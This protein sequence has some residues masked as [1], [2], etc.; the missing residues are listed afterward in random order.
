MEFFR[1]KLGRNV[2]SIVII[3]RIRK[4]LATN[5]HFYVNLKNLKLRGVHLLISISYKGLILFITRIFN[6]IYLELSMNNFLWQ[7][8]GYEYYQKDAKKLM[9]C[10]SRD[11]NHHHRHL[12]LLPNNQWH[13]VCPYS[14]FVKKSI[15]FIHYEC[16][17][18]VSLFS[19]FLYF[20][21]SLFRAK[22]E[23][24]LSTVRVLLFQVSLCAAGELPSGSLLC[25]L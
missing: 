22:Y 17:Q 24:L 5:S 25:S 7:V 12:P 21:P 9:A 8:W 4:S 3:I 13:L 23:K 1:N 10:L 2:L 19:F 20:S 15:R 14:G 11:R 18:N 16:E 6:V